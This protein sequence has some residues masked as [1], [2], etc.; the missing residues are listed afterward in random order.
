MIVPLFVQ[1][2]VE[3]FG[4]T[5]GLVFTIVVLAIGAYVGLSVLGMLWMLLFGRQMGP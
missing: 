3:M 4:Q 5:G 2:A 1:W